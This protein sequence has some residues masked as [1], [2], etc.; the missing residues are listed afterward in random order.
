VQ[1]NY[2]NFN[3]T[4]ITPN[5]KR[6][7]MDLEISIKGCRE[8]QFVVHGGLM[9]QLMQHYYTAFVLNYEITNFRIMNDLHFQDRMH[10]YFPYINNRKVLIISSFAELIKEQYDS[11]NLERIY[12][13]YTYPTITK[14]EIYVFPY[15]FMNDGTDANYFE[16]LQNTYDAIKTIEFDVA[17][18]GCGAY[19]HKLCHL[20][21]VEL[22][23]D[24]IYM[25]GAI[26]TFFGILSAREK[27]NNK[28]RTNEYWITNI[29]EKYKPKHYKA[30]EDGCYW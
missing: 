21:D 9:M 14:M 11:G 6:F 10:E 23:K 27:Q 17:L 18:L 30:I 13:E 3:T 15:C 20:I 25:G 2:F 12:P 26:Q 7:I 16:T 5:F 28:N 24:A 22:N 8:T 29:P 1:G 19:G 4:A